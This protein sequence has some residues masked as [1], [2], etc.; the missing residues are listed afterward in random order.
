M[1]KACGID[2]T[3]CRLLD[4]GNRAHFMIRRFDRAGGEKM[5]MQTLCALAHYDYNLSGGYSYEDAFGVMRMVR[6]PYDDM[7]Q[8]FRRIVFNMI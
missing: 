5:H 3:E 8:M 7:E 4:T 2:M 6:L 1:A